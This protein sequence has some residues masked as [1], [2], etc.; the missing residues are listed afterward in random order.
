M[1]IEIFRHKVRRRRNAEAY[2]LS[3]YLHQCWNALLHFLAIRKQLF[4]LLNKKMLFHQNF[5]CMLLKMENTL[6]SYNHLVLNFRFY[7]SL[8]VIYSVQDPRKRCWLALTN[9]ANFGRT[10]LRRFLCPFLVHL[11]RSHEVPLT[12]MLSQY[13]TFALYISALR[14]I[15]GQYVNLLC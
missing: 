14:R 6:V 10:H 5:F 15:L 13:A 8:A 1:S 11:L 7:Q 3:E 9:F 4:L 2:Y 12:K